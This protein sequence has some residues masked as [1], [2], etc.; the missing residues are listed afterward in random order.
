MNPR[1]NKKQIL[2]LSLLLILAVA[3][4]YYQVLS[5]EFVNY[6]D[7]AYVGENEH[8]LPGFTTE[9]I[10]WAFTTNWTANWHPLT[11]L[12]LMLDC[13][14]AAPKNTPPMVHFT[15]LTLHI[16]NTLLL[17]LVFWK[18]TGSIW[19]S[20]FLA[21][22]F[23]VHPV[24]VESVAWAA[25]RKDVLSTFFWLAVMAVYISY[26]RRHT[27]PKYLAMTL[28]FIL[29]LMAKPM[30]VT[31][32]IVLLLLDYWPLNR[33]KSAKNLAPLLLEKIPL[34]IITLA[35]CVVTFIFQRSVGVVKSL[36]VLSIP[37]RLG[38]AATSYVSYISKMLWPQNLAVFYPYDFFQ[39]TLQFASAAALLLFLTILLIWLGRRHRFL[40]V[41]WL[42]YLGTMI[43]V[44]G[45]VQVGIQAMADRYTYIPSIGFFVVI[46]WGSLLL[47]DRL[48]LPRL[49]PGIIGIIAV[50]ILAVCCWFQVA[51]WKNN[52][53]LYKHAIAVTENNNVAHNNLA[54]ALKQQGRIDEALHHWQTVLQIYPD[55]RDSI[56][57]LGPTLVDHGKPEQA[58]AT[59]EKYLKLC[60][61]DLE[62]RK[63]LAYALSKAGQNDQAFAEYQKVLLRAEDISL[64][65]G[66]AQLFEKGK[67]YD[68]ALKH[69]Q[70]I[71]EL[72]PEDSAVRTL[73]AHALYQL[74]RY[75]ESFA[76]Y[77]KALK[78]TNNLPLRR[79]VAGLMEKQKRFDLAIEQYQAILK[80]QPN[81][82]SACEK[83][84]FLYFSQKKYDDAITWFTQSTKISPN[85]PSAHS[86][87]ASALALANRYEEAIPHFQQALK[88]EPNFKPALKG[89]QAAQNQIKNQP[90]RP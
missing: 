53:T 64:R 8:V 83:I 56:L 6:D 63:M 76:E 18:M 80:A 29:G 13:Q 49:L 24:H 51:T 47:A 25:E 60:P 40:T 36:D 33:L 31:L 35:S 34:F 68:L 85:Q 22:I 15:S 39:T 43:P 23:G 50:S 90:D 75:D 84:G 73:L 66:I 86:N 28:L 12:S 20:W 27:V 55:Y 48:H 88:L 21:I 32:P 74:G 11:W 89:L 41:G 52:E 81:D 9:G 44:I 69:Y 45:L 1:P 3:G 16:A 42:W 54:V 61:N 62:I 30:L 79:G 57:G 17:F 58:V 4:V 78:S 71:L 37:M 77:Q 72:K 14:I 82:Y 38:N 19:P 46:I 87:L 65:K 5:H 10:A 7:L 2:I 26:A 70:K 59:Y 67:R